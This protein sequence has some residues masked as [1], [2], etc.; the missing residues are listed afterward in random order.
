MNPPQTGYR[1]AE[2]LTVFGHGT[3]GY[4]ITALVEFIAQGVVAQRAA[5]VLG[6]NYIP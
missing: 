2:L 4:G 1:Y 6:I 3:T 5:T